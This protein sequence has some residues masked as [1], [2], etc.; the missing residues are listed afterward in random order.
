MWYYESNHQP[1]GPVSEEEISELLQ[2][3]TITAL[4][5]VWKEGMADWKH[6][7]ETEL[8][9]L[10][11]R[12]APVSPLPQSPAFTM[13]AANAESPSYATV[14]PKYARGNTGAT[15]R[16]KPKTLKNLFTWWAVSLV[17]VT[18][19]DIISVMIPSNTALVAISCVADLFILTFTVLQFVL[20]YQF[21][22]VNQDGS[23]GTT[24]GKAVGY[25]FIPIFNLY[26]LFRAYCGLANDQNR[27]IDRHFDS[28][29]PVK[30]SH[31]LISVIYLISSIGG[32][33]VLYLILS[34][35]TASKFINSSVTSASELASMSTMM[36]AF[37]IPIAIF[38]AVIMIL[39]FWMYNDFYQCAKSITETEEKQQ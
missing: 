2:T 37:S 4:T 35:Q 16:V 32:S 24:P 19:Y 34:F 22:K 26:W 13:P 38:S 14:A 3:G 27:Y 18:F 39:S 23:A 31:L 21:W 20:L 36:S 10:S 8:S 29:T 7:G 1:T 12:V 9:S 11:H 15:P 30:R 6:L 5:L 28:T 17:V 25:L 33:F